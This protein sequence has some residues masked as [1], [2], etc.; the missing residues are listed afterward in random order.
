M[1]LVPFWINGTPE[2]T[3]KCI[4]YH[5]TFLMVTELHLTSGKSMTGEIH[6]H[7]WMVNV[8]FSQARMKWNFGRS[9]HISQYL[10]R[11]GLIY[12]SVIFY[13]RVRPIIAHLIT[14]ALIF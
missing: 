14:N 5:K 3:Y 6:P 10:R 11:V 7:A 1:C 4:I 12:F 13:T 2:L 8:L 9:G